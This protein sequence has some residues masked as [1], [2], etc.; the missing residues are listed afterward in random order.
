MKLEYDSPSGK[1]VHQINTHERIVLTHDNTKIDIVLT[2]HGKITIS[3]EKDN[4][5]WLAIRPAREGIMT[6]TKVCKMMN[7]VYEMLKSL[8]VDRG[9][10]LLLIWIKSSD[11]CL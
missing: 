8:T 6:P 9:Q 7:K 3:G 4:H 1:I 10:V 2:K 5:F 11:D